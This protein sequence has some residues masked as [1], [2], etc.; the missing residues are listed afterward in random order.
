MSKKDERPGD[1]EATHGPAVKRGTLDDYR[2]RIR[3]VD[4]EILELV[5]RRLQLAHTIGEEKKKRH[6]PIQDFK[7]EKAVVDRAAEVCRT[8]GIDEGIGEAVMQPLIRHAV[9]V[10]ETDR[11]RAAS[12]GG[13][14]R[15][16]IIGGAGH[17]GRWFADFLSSQGHQITI[18]DPAGPVGD[19]ES[20][21]EVEDAVEQADV[22]IIATPPSVT[23]SILDDIGTTRTQAV[24]FD[25]CSLKTPI[26]GSLES[27]A[28]R[29]FQVASIHPMFG[30]DTDLLSGRH[31][32][33]CSLG[34]ERAVQAVR[35]F[36]SETCASLVEM[37]LDEHDHL[38]AYVLGLSHAINILFND[39]LAH[40]DEELPRVLQVSSVTF[41][42]QFAVASQLA[43]ENPNL[44]YEIQAL[45][46]YTPDLIAS[47]EKSLARF[48]KN[49][50]RKD[51]GGF[52]TM[53][54]EASEYYRTAIGD[55]APHETK[56]KGG[57]K[58][59]EEKTP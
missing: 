9:K 50:Q 28:D 55:E 37:T 26:R 43:S 23:S 35:S 22:A 2:R 56:H 44:Y 12:A 7:I 38:V 52:V 36:F 30:P 4:D 10:Q 48:T 49:V 57:R 24:I 33:V 3:E 19:Y 59:E 13:G 47:L 39:V 40:S 42:R 16:L 51:R 41:D 45:N 27:L 25:V 18:L 6:L 14:K 32:I 46:H 53:M 15:V 17:M 11:V 5:A 31:V 8:L 20:A 1:D 21:T 58:A 29:G 34:H 54:R